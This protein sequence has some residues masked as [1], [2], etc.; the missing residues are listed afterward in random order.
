MN[1]SAPFLRVHKVLIMEFGLDAAA[2]ISELVFKQEMFS[3]AFFYEQKKIEKVT[4]LSRHRQEK[5]SKILIDNGILSIEKEKKGIP[6]KKFYRVKIDKYYELVE[7][8]QKELPQKRK[9]I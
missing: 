1:N 2:L 3:G 8:L 9:K 6:P 4:G 5:A 7:R